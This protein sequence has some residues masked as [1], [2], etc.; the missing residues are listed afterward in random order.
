MTAMMKQRFTKPKNALL[1]ENALHLREKRQRPLQLVVLVT[2]LVFKLFSFCQSDLVCSS[3][4]RSN[5]F[6]AFKDSQPCQF[7]DSAPLPLDS[8]LPVET[9]DISERTVRMLSEV[10]LLNK[11]LQ[12]SD[13][14]LKDEYS[15]FYE[16]FTHDYYE[17][18]QGQKAIIV[19]GSR[20][21]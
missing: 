21:L 16:R 13:S 18:G 5:P 20:N 1:N 12:R 17:Y 14:L 8:A 19:R 3:L 4:F 10:Q 9:S 2:V 7:V 15:F 6:E 11:P